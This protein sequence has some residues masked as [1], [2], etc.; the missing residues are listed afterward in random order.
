MGKGIK[1]L[2]TYAV[3]YLPLSPRD[4]SE[5]TYLFVLIIIAIH[6]NTYSGKH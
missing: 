1:C 5:H 3:S 2:G 4:P 6:K